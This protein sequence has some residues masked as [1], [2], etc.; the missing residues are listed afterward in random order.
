M[1]L[2]YNGYMGF[3]D[4]LFNRAT[5]LTNTGSDIADQAMQ[6]A[7][8]ATSQVNDQVQNL[9]DSALQDAADAADTFFGNS[10]E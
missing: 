4:E 6:M 3:F 1:L 2:C 8:D 5:E 10:Q 9:N 7:E